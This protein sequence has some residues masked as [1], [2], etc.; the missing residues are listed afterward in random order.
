[1]KDAVGLNII[2]RN[3]EWVLLKRTKIRVRRTISAPNHRC[4]RLSMRR[5]IDASEYNGD[6]KVLTLKLHLKFV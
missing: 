4:V 6:L 1:M 5:T 3:I 2:Q